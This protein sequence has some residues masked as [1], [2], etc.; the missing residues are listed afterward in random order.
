MGNHSYFRYKLSYFD[1]TERNFGILEYININF[2]NGTFFEIFQ[3]FL[4]TSFTEKIQTRAYTFDD[5]VGSCGGFIGL[6]LGYA[7]IQIPHSI[8]SVLLKKW[9]NVVL[10]KSSNTRQNEDEN[11]D[12]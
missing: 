3:Y 4:Q 10:R 7:L 9:E 12:D 2:R 11:I 6:F 8:E 5:L 1:K